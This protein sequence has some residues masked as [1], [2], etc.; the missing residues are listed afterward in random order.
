LANLGLAREN[1]LIK[2]RLYYVNKGKSCQHRKQGS[3][4][5]IQTPKSHPII[6]RKKITC[7]FLLGKDSRVLPNNPACPEGF[8]NISE[9]ELGATMD[10]TSAIIEAAM[11]ETGTRIHRCVM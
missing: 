10:V 7:N 8:S 6:V 1:L 5:E 9:P 3:L 2:R 11:Q 4:L